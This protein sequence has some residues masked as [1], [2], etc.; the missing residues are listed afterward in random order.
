M[1]DN[2]DNCSHFGRKFNETS[3]LH[4]VWTQNEDKLCYHA[5][6]TAIK[7]HPTVPLQKQ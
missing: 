5:S 2:F 4:Q 7:H 3:A 6:E 1:A